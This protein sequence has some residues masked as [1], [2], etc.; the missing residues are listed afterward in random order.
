MRAHG[1]A[2]RGDD[3]YNENEKWTYTNMNEPQPHSH[4]MPMAEN[5][6]P[7]NACT[8]ARKPRQ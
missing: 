4:K 7:R 5:E 8:R 1:H 3:R 2:N 6:V